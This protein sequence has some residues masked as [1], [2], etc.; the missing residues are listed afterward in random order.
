MNRGANER[1][2]G[3]L[4][5]QLIRPGSRSYDETRAL[6]NGMID[7]RPVLVARCAGTADVIACVD[8][9]RGQ[10]LAL[11][12]RGGGHGVAGKAACDG[13]MIDLSH[14]RDVHVD[15]KARVARVGGGST[16]GTVDHETQAFGL[17]VTGGV[18]SRTGVGGLTLGG[19]IGYLAR[20]H[21]LT[22]DSLL[23]AEVVLADGSMVTASATENP[24]LFWALRGGGGGF[25][26]VTTFEFQLHAVGPEVMTA[27]VFHGMDGAAEA[28]A[29]YRDFMSTAPDEAACYPLFVNVPPVD[30]FPPQHHGKT[31][32]VFVGCHAGSLEDGEEALRPLG[33]FG[34]PFF[35]AI[36]PMPYATL[37]S[38]FDAGAPDGGRFY[39]KAHYLD[40]LSDALIDLLVERVDPLPGP[41]SNVFVECLGGA[42]ARVSSDAT[43]FPHRDVPFSLGVSS[44]WA[45][46]A[47]DERAIAW[48]RSLFEATAPHASGGVYVNYLDR[49]E[50]DRI[51]AAYGANLP[52]L[53]GV[54]RMYDP[55]GLFTRAE[56]ATTVA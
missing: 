6:W 24:D 14:M 50:D 9:A 52:R 46:A 32:L 28:L 3:M 26:I 51:A 53:E 7:R 16:W 45:D 54:R 20:A 31:A 18:D 48:T 36:A 12:V 34:A 4:R 55:E 56:A 27:Q 37:Q 33:E 41:Y 11:S 39:W 8:F 19:G 42:V 5:G 30:P 13:L 40:E 38:S 22:I 21:G 25:G 49:D 15:A 10:D 23:S 29:F 17:A 1:F 47:E 35:S 2:A 44:G 43:A